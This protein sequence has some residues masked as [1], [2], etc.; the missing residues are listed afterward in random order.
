M[1][2]SEPSPLFEQQQRCLSAEAPAEGHLSTPDP[3]PQYRAPNAYFSFPDFL[4]GVAEYRP[5]LSV[6]L[7]VFTI[8]CGAFRTSMVMSV[9]APHHRQSTMAWS[10]CL[11]WLA[12]PSDV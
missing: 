2:S 10:F 6:P 12:T 4:G 8:K 3:K 11:G 7:S 5:H 1:T 9:S